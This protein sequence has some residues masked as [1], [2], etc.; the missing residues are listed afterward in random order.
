VD[1]SYQQ[2]FL[3][4]DIRVPIMSM[5]SFLIRIIQV[6]MFDMDRMWKETSYDMDQAM[7]PLLPKREGIDMTS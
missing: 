4:G 3:V 6:P 1:Q 2:S 7:G 5:G